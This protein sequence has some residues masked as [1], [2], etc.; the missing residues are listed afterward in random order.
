MIKSRVLTKVACA[1]TLLAL[2]SATAACGGQGQ[3]GGTHSSRKTLKVGVL[4]IAQA[5][6]V[7]DTV[8][9]FETAL[10]STFPNLWVKF[11][12]K[13]A[14]GRADLI[15]A[16]VRGLHQSD[17]D[18]FAVMGTPA[19]I[20]MTKAET[21]RPIIALA[22]SDPVSSGVARSLGAPG[23]NVTGSTD[24]IDPS[25]QLRDI[26]RVKPRAERLGTV[27]DPS[28]AASQEWATALK[29]RVRTYSM[30]LAEEHVTD[31]ASVSQAVRRLEGRVDS[32][33]IGPDALATGAEQE[34]ATIAAQ[35]N[36]PLYVTAGDASTPGLTAVLGPDYG[37]V[38]WQAGEQAAMVVK[39]K[40]VKTVP[41]TKPESA[42]A[43]FNMATVDQLGLKVPVDL[44]RDAR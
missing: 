38:G 40:S 20:A 31:A 44:L 39:G 30:T 5:E 27:Y 23:E 29:S 37:Q 28:N 43:Q 3:T 33:L 25:L 14:Q 13:N 9:G 32:L 16:A 8:K 15:R 1:A 6:V 35:A 7:D 24:F 17:D 4:K 12:V 22:M 18:M 42:R 36:L 41:F 19:V 34:I 11:D 26:T 10:Q 2:S 21:R